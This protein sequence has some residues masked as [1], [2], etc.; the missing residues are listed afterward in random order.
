LG[1]SASGYFISRNAPSEQLKKVFGAGA[2]P[3]SNVLPSEYPTT[4][5]ERQCLETYA[6]AGITYTN[7]RSS[8]SATV[9]CEALYAFAYVASQ[10]QGKLTARSFAAAYSSSGTRYQPVVT[11]GVDFGNGRRD[12]AARYRTFGY[13]PACSCLRYSGPL[14]PL[15]A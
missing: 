3:L 10:V 9:Y 2:F 12:N 15:P 13:T 7:R 8:I 5:R 1:D 6:K 4:P 11:F 14:R